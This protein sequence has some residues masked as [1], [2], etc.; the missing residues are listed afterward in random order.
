M[1]RQHFL[2]NLWRWKCGLPELNYDESKDRFPTLEELRKSEWSN[3]FEQK[4]RDRLIF[5]AMRY[6]CMGH[7]S[8]P[9]GKPQYD[10]ISSIRARLGFFEATGNAEWLVDIANMALLMYEERVHPNFHFKSVDGDDAQAYHDEI[11]KE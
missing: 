9:P 5:G 7:G 1:D 11:I 2:D 10:R 3:D 8:I 6:G 4:M